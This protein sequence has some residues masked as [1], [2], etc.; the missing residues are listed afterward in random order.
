MNTDKEIDLFGLKASSFGPD[1]K[2]GVATSAYQIEGAY[3]AD[4][5]GPSIW[6][7]FTHKK[8]WPIPTVLTGENGDVACDF[9]HLYKEDIALMG[10]LGFKVNRF[11]ISWPRILPDGNG[12]VNQKGLDFYSRVVDESLANG[13]EPWITLYHWDLPQAL[14]NNGGWKNRQIISSFSNYVDVVSKALGDRVKNWMVFNEPMSFC[15]GGYLLGIHAP[16]EIGPKGFMQAVHN[17]NLCQAKAAQIIRGNDS[18]AQVG[19]THV[20][21]PIS[22]KGRNNNPTKAEKSADALLHKIFLEP[23]LG[24]GYPVKENPIVS[25]VER[26]IVGDDADDIKVDFDFIGVQYYSPSLAIPVPYL[27]SIPVPLRGIK[28]QDRD[29]MGHFVNP[30]G[31][32]DALVRIDSYEGVKKL[33]ITENGMSLPD[34]VEGDRV[35][36]LRRIDYLRQHLNTVKRAQDNGIPVSGYFY[37]S[38]LDNFEWALGF[39]PRFGIV[40]VD[41]NTLKRTP[42]D[43]AYWIQKFLQN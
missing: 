31:L 19:T 29:Q 3:D 33:I 5:K 42:K 12:R 21:A 14:Q 6:D 39:K 13:I 23:N 28:G 11:S 27:H 25:L 30:S 32:Y 24:L 4:G 36:D 35:Y 1:F 16:G 8:R 22:H 7:T 15:I 10:T 9:Y 41:K 26:Y 43:S 34:V 2:F 20:V 38:F 37:W 17:V 18:S 40:H